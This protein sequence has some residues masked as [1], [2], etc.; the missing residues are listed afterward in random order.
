MMLNIAAKN[1]GI[2]K[3][4]YRLL[5]KKNYC[6]II[7]TTNPVDAPENNAIEKVQEIY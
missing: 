5:Q 1:A 7:L 2:K 3:Y 4:Q 6:K